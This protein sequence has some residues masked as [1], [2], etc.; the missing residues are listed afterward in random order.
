[1]PGSNAKQQE[2]INTRVAGGGTQTYIAAPSGTAADA[3]STR[4]GLDTLTVI[5]LPY[6]FTKHNIL[7]ITQ[8]PL[9]GDPAYHSDCD[10]WSVVGTTITVADA[11]FAATDILI[12]H[13]TGTARGSGFVPG[14]LAVDL[15]GRTLSSDVYRCSPSTAEPG[16]AVWASGTT[17]TLGGLPWVPVSSDVVYLRINRIGGTVEHYYSSEDFHMTGMVLTI[18]NLDS[19]LLDDGTESYTV[20]LMGPERAY[21]DAADLYRTEIVNA[22]KC[23]YEE[24][25]NEVDATAV[26][27][28]FYEVDTQGYKLLGIYWVLTDGVMTLFS[29]ADPIAVVP[30]EG[31][32]PSTDWVQ[33]GAAID[34]GAGATVNAARTTQTAARSWLIQWVPYDATSII[35]VNGGRIPNV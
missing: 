33:E 14:T 7:W 22:P 31:G 34:S 9:S 24:W 32:A 29:A 1:M 18:D 28:N 13:L 16:T 35:V 11:V 25:V 19:V 10:K 6:T 23:F 21:V 26:A 8:K 4:T 20:T 5:G 27:T 15:I 30:A 17:L 2:I 3:V 12:V